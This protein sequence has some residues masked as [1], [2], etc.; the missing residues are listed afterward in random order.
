MTMANPQVKRW[1]IFGA[2]AYAI[3][4]L[5]QLP[6]RLLGNTLNRHGIATGALTGSIWHG[7]AQRLQAGIL[8]LGTVEWQWRFL[9]LFAGRLA[10]DVSVTT[11]DSGHADSRI[12]MSVNG[13]V[14]LSNFTASLPLQ[15]IVGSGGLPGG[16]MGRTQARL[17][18]LV[19]KDGWPVAA[20]GELD[21][22][23]LT[24]PAQA[25]SNIGSYHLS[26]PASGSN[27]HTLIGTLT[28]RD[29]AAIAATG[30]LKLGSDRSYVLDT[31]VMARAN[32]PASIVDGMKYLGPA[33][34]QGRRPFSVSGTF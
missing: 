7:H 23:D 10:A 22:I 26:F 4:L 5:S 33:D 29:G 2:L 8:N 6:A 20:S 17:Q 12:A 28:D 27:E 24:G 1:L 3:F 19:L 25:P 30:T 11:A 13:K 16:W 31:L 15:S 32:A 18:Q 21:V 14:I 34:A 9:P